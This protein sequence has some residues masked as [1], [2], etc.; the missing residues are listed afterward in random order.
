MKARLSII[1]ESKADLVVSIHQNSFG[2]SSVRGPQVFYYESGE[3]GA[4]VGIQLPGELAAIDFH[5]GSAVAGGAGI[6]HGTAV[7]QTAVVCLHLFR[8][9]E[10]NGGVVI[11]KV[12]GHSLD[13]IL[14]A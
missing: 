6:E 8:G 1:E 14:D 4:D 11:C 10:M 9:D 2:D 12:V 7:R 5:F 3:N 13:F